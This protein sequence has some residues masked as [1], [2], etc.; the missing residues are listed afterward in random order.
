MSKGL[1][2]IKS[3]FREVSGFGAYEII[4]GIVHNVNEE[5]ALVDIA[6]QEDVF[7]YDVK[8]RAV[9]N[10][11]QSGLIC[12]PKVGSYV[13]VA[14]IRNASN[15]VLIQCSELDKII[16]DTAI[17]TELNSEEI[18]FNGGLKG[19]LVTIEELKQ[20]LEILKNYITTMNTS[21]ST[22]LATLDASAGSA[23]SAPYNGIMSTMQINFADMENDKIK[24]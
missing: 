2:E 6:I 15:Y 3:L 19:G 4:D 5:K 24:Q 23:S 8:L 16:I 18:V 9:S 10:N 13:V 17:K 14:K 22:A 7:L 1:Q 20:N 12:I 11:H 21:V